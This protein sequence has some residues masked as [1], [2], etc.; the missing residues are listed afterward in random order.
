MKIYEKCWTKTNKQLPPDCKDVMLYDGEKK[1]IGHFNS[2]APAKTPYWNPE[3]DEWV[4]NI[5]HWKKK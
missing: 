3:E 2:G 1:F 4:G 5:T